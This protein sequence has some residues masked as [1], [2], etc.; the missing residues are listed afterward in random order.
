M[1]ASGGAVS[2]GTQPE[3]TGDSG[4]SEADLL[5]RSQPAWREHYNNSRYHCLNLHSVF[6][7]GTIEFQAV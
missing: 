5:Q 2:G 6:Q 3:E 1:Q 4:E 7:K